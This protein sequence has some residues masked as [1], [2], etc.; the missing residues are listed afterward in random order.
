[1]EEFGLLQH[2]DS[3]SPFFVRPGRAVAVVILLASIHTTG[4]SGAVNTA[5][6]VRL[7]TN[8]DYRGYSRSD[9]HPTVQ[10]NV[11]SRYT[12]G[13]FLGAWV[14][15]VD[16]DDARLEVNPYLGT[17]FT[18]TPDWQVAT[19]LA[20]YF[21][22][23]KVMGQKADYA[24]AMAQLAFRD[25]G[26]ARFYLAPDYAGLGHTVANCELELR[27][28]LTDTIEVSGGLGYQASRDALNYDFVT[29]N[30]GVAW[31]VLPRLTL[32]LRY[33]AS[34]ETNGKPHDDRYAPESVFASEVHPPVIFSVSIG[35]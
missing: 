34:H 4:A 24:Q 2:P 3:L 16:M 9:N 28:P 11:D 12:S 31:F 8:Y 20:G 7:T 32:D 33:H 26:S 22:D 18:L 5:G 6:I 25:T 13:L 17:S 30:A 23:D 27:Y 1:M 19:S 10:V 29:A 15:A 35:F 14:S 21:F